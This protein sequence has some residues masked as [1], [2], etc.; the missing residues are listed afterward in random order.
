[1]AAGEVVD[2]YPYPDEIRFANG[3]GAERRPSPEATAVRSAT[4]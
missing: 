4:R 3:F 2:F 1:V